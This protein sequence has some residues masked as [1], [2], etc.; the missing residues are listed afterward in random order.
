MVFRR[1]ILGAV[2]ALLLPAAAL[3]AHGKVGL[4]SSTTSVAIP[5]MPAQTHTATYCMT[6]AEVGSDTPRSTNPSCVYQ[7]VHVSGHTFSADMVCKGQFNATGHFTSTYDSD[8]HY[9]AEIA[10]ATNGMTMTNTVDGKW[11]KAD[12][13]GATQ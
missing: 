10:I 1:V 7:N 12:C 3:A 11:L 6:A 8:T 4:W 9:T 5:G 13:G 2:T